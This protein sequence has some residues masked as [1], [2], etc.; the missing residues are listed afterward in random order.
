MMMVMWGELPGALTN[1]SSRKN[2]DP[3]GTVLS[4]NSRDM[5]SVEDKLSKDS[6]RGL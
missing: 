2:T 6:R 1:D 3:A 4:K 5:E